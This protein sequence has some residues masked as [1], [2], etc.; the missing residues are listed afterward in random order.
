MGFENDLIFNIPKDL[1]HFKDITMGHP[2]IMGKKTWQSIP[3]KFRPL[4]GRVNIV[5]SRGA[6]EFPGAEKAESVEEALEKAGSHD[7]EIYII[8]GAKIFELALPH[9]DELILTEIDGNKPSDA[10]FPAF[11]K[12]F[13]EA[14]KEGPFEHEDLKYW[15]VNYRRR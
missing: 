3:E 5:V 7:T 11:E 9:I 12:D 10:F 15:F 2:V 13:I 1:K 8:G 4:P 14:K 6:D